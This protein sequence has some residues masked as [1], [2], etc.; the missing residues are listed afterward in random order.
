MFKKIK[1]IHNLT[2]EKKYIPQFCPILHLLRILFSIFQIILYL[3]LHTWPYITNIF[4]YHEK[5]FLKMILMT[6]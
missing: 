3:V 6:L 1:I 2:I 4:T 5:H